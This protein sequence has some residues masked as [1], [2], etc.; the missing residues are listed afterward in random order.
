MEALFLKIAQGIA[1]RLLSEKLFAGLLVMGMQAISRRTS[2]NLDDKLTR[3]V[4]DALGR[5]DLLDK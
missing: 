4:A 2:T 5:G 1:L 3:D